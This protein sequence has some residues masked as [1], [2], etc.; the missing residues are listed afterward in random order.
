MAF[1]SFG[2]PKAPGPGSDISLGTRWRAEQG[3]SKMTRRVQ[4]TTLPAP[5]YWTSGPGR[6]QLPAPIL[7]MPWH[8]HIST[9]QPLHG[10]ICTS[11]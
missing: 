2:F 5:G 6:Q 11:N 8:H 1:L 9:E 7:V 10:P 4:A 3:H